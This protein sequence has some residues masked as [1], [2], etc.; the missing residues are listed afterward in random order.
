VRQPAS[1]HRMG[2][3]D[4]VRDTEVV[5][6]QIEVVDLSRRW[7]ARRGASV[8]VEPGLLGLRL[9]GVFGPRQVWR[10]PLDAVAVVVTAR[11]DEPDAGGGQAFVEPLTIPYLATAT[12]WAAPNLVLLFDR[13]RRLAPVTLRGAIGGALG[14]GLHGRPSRSGQGLWVDGVRLRAVDPYAMSASLVRAGA[15]QVTAPSRWMAERRTRTTDP[16][17]VARA[18]AAQRR[19]WLAPW[20]S[21]LLLAA[22]VVSAGA[23]ERGGRWWAAL[24]GAGLLAV[25]VWL[26]G[27]L[28][29][30]RRRRSR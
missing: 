19:L 23:A 12:A 8:E 4:R 25:A 13:R 28:R 11:I 20:L 22:F 5:S 29:R 27:A 24:G 16:V 1:R 21:T 14:V 17:A 18:R 30:G 7:L 3:A 2:D 10:L 6:Q 15:Q 9:P 26:P